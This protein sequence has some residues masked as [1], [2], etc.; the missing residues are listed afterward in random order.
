MRTGV[1][2]YR[3]EGASLSLSRATFIGHGSLRARVALYRAGNSVG[4]ARFALFIFSIFL[5]TLQLTQ[6]SARARERGRENTRGPFRR[7]KKDAGACCCGPSLRF[8][9][10]PTILFFQ[11][12]FSGFCK[13]SSFS[14]FLSLSLSRSFSRSLGP[15]ERY[16]H[17]VAAAPGVL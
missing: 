16:I 10:H 8:G 2:V 6:R 14:V 9:R 17:V 3:W 4:E 7:K 11:V 15:R 12:L 13:A 5:S 1:H